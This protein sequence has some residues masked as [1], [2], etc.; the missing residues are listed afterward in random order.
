MAGSVF[1]DCVA[2]RRWTRLSSVVEPTTRLIGSPVT[3]TQRPFL[4][5]RADREGTVISGWLGRVA[6]YRFVVRCMI[7]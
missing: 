6:V 1:V 7:V 4:N 3:V 2:A 5:A